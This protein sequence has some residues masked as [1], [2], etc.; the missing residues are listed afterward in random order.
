MDKLKIIGITIIIVVG[1]IFIGYS[2]KQSNP[3]GSVMDFGVPRI[4]I[5]TSEVKTVTSD[6]QIL[7]TSTAR[8]YAIICNDSSNVVYLNMDDDKPASKLAGFRLNAN[9]GCYEI[10]G[11]NLYVGGVHASSTNETSSNLLISDYK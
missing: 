11:D 1:I 9:G 6:S 7:A 4:T 5:A 8:T 2:I 10:N 3:V